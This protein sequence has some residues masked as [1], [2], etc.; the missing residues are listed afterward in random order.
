MNAF[1]L[2]SNEVRNAIVQYL[3]DEKKMDYFEG[4]V[5][6]IFGLDGSVD[7]LIYANVPR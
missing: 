6:L 7:I 2:T 3:V 1:K 5:D 4:N